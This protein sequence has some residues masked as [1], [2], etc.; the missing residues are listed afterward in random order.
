M[1]FAIVAP[2]FFLLIFG[3]IEYG[4]MVMVQQVITN[5]SREG[6]RRAVLDGAT[7]TGVVSA[8]NEILDS[9]AVDSDAADVIVSPDPP[10][11]AGF[12]GAVTV[13]VQIPFAKVS[14]LPSPMY[15]GSTTLEAK[16]AMRRET[17]Q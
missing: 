14:W 12:G 5:A 16:T 6:A 7:T 17:V 15:L 3:M 11:N 10:E 2:L 13:T 8:V 4:R 9:A 1:E